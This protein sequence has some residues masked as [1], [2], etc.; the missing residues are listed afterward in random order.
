M[1]AP[2]GVAAPWTCGE[3]GEEVAV[4]AEEKPRFGTIEENTRHAARMLREIFVRDYL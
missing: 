2:E 4:A 1:S 3:A